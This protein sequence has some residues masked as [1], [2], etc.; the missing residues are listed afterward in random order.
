MQTC[1]DALIMKVFP[2]P[3]SDIFWFPSW[4][5]NEPMSGDNTKKLKRKDPT[6]R[7]VSVSVT[8]DESSRHMRIE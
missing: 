4:G 7:G 2:N 3:K 8:A 5:E 1:S 6:K